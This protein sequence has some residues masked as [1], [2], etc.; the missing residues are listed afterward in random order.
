M[1]EGV[2]GGRWRHNLQTVFIAIF[3]FQHPSLS[4]G[5]AAHP[6]LYQHKIKAF[7]V[8]QNSEPVAIPIYTCLFLLLLPLIVIHLDSS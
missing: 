2:Q 6:N 1:G 5:E 8:C 7:Q 3:S 4:S